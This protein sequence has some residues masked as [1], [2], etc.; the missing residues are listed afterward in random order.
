[1]QEVLGNESDQA[2]VCP[3][4]TEGTITERKKE[5]LA[6]L[7]VLIILV[8]SSL[9][10]CFL[11]NIFSLPTFCSYMFPLLSLFFP[12]VYPIFIS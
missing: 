7:N 6:Y 10:H 4:E 1:M 12:S 9:N 8:F 5:E 11:L 3:A 2:V